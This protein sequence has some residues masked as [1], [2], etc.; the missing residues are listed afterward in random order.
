MLGL[1]R[2]SLSDALGQAAR[3]RARPLAV[4]PPALELPAPF[5]ARGFARYETVFGFPPQRTNKKF[6]GI[7]CHPGRAFGFP[8]P[9]KRQGRR[10]RLPNVKIRPYEYR[11]APSCDGQF[12]LVPPYPPRVNR[13]IE[14]EPIRGNPWPTTVHKSYPLRW[15]NIEYL[16]EPRL[17]RK[18]FANGHQRWSGPVTRIEHRGRGKSVMELV[19]HDSRLLDW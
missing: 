8:K 17:M 15:K 13:T 19:T 6:K 10:K 3:A 1:L 16:Y 7:H 14:P 5:G 12:Y 9:Q 2:R 11:L 18:P 4:L